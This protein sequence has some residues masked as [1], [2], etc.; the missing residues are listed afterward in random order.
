LNKL[1][2]FQMWS[3]RRVLSAV[4]GLAASSLALPSLAQAYPDRPI[5]VIV[6]NPP[7]GINDT[8]MRAA[9]IDAAKKLGQPILIDNKPGAAG[10]VSFLALKNAAPD[11]YTI[12][13]TTPPLWRQPILQDV[14]YDPIK[15]FT[16]IINIAE[17]VFAIVVR[18]DSPFKTW[19]DVLA[20]SRANPGKISYGAPPGTN[21]TG[22]I[23]VE[24]MARKE[25]MQWE[26]IGYKGSSESITALLGGFV[27]F[28]MEPVVGVS[29]MLRSGKV[30][31]LAVATPYRLKSWPDVPS[32]KDLGYPITVDSPTGIAG[33]A[34]LSPQIVKTLHDAFKF[35]LEQPALMS[36]LAQSDQVPRYMSSTEYTSYVARAEQEQRELLVS[37][38]MAKKP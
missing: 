34:H 18:Q 2:S 12:G 3:R 4:S 13:L 16:Y 22:H 20:Y 32:F 10:V 5:R 37:Y 35:A 31:A 27:A 15:D 38:G 25:H 14:S 24:G 19:A 33:P 11:G 1:P 8:V 29:A 30:R 6:G 7:G 28:S 9:A 26:P 36:V 17:S 23:L 21:Q